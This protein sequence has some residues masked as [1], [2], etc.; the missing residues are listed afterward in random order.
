MTKQ[1]PIFVA[2]KGAAHIS[3]KTVASA[4]SGI[5]NAVRATKEELLT[6]GRQSI[7]EDNMNFLATAAAKDAYNTVSTMLSTKTDEELE[8]AVQQFKEAKEEKE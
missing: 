2:M 6:A 5:V 4:G 7:R 3:A 8:E 1:N